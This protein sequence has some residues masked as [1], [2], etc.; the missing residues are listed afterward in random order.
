[1]PAVVL[2][3]VRR[4]GIAPRRLRRVLAHVLRRHRA[5]ARAQVTVVLVSDRAIRVL[6]RRF[7]RKD[8]STDVLAF[9]GGDRSFLGEVV[10]SV[11]RA[12]AQAKAA[13]HDPATEI[14]LLAAHGLLHLLGYSDRTAARRAWMMRRQRR[15]LHELGIEVRG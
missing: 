6:N 9:P 14:A 5:P 4:P 13:G 2:A 7:L 11:D 10:V 8:R 1:M 3:K 15:L 12:R